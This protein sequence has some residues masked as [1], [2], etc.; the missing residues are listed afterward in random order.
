MFGVFADDVHAAG[1]PKRGFVFGTRQQST[2]SILVFTSSV[3]P[4]QTHAAVSRP[5][6]PTVTCLNVCFAKRFRTSCATAHRPMA[7]R[8][9]AAALGLGRFPA[10][11]P[12]REAGGRHSML[13]PAIP[14]CRRNL[15]GSR[16]RRTSPDQGPRQW[17]TILAPNSLLSDHRDEVGGRSGDVSRRSEVRRRY[18]GWSAISSPSRARDS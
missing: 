17:L 8:D 9:L 11:R 2:A 18:D 14:V 13:R 6:Q 5:S 10:R 1:F 3:Y 15:A 4:S 16:R 12:R 7:W